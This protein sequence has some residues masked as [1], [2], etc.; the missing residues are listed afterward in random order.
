MFSRI[1]IKSGISRK[2]RRHNGAYSLPPSRNVTQKQGAADVQALEAASKR[3]IVRQH[4]TNIQVRRAWPEPPPRGLTSMR[5]ALKCDRA[6]SPLVPDCKHDILFVP[7]VTVSSSS[8]AA[9]PDGKMVAIVLRTKESGPLGFIVTR[10][11]CAAL[12]C[13]IAIA[14]TLLR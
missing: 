6:E 11:S 5:F 12:R 7:T 8:V 10:E 13:Q 14:E 2:T 9:S 3:A 4:P 1:I